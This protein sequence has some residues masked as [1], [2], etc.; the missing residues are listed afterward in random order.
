MSLRK[1]AG[2]T[3]EDVSTASRQ[4]AATADWDNLALIAVAGV[5]VVA[6]LIAVVALE[7]SSK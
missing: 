3:L 5:A 6:M 2:K 1:Q 4:I 7:R